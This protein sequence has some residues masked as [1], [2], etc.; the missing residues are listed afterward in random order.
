MT[1][2]DEHTATP[3][4]D[5]RLTPRVRVALLSISAT[6]AA[7]GF[8]RLLGPFADVR[9]DHPVR[10]VVALVAFALAERTLLYLKFRD[11][12]VCYTPS[13]VLLAIGLLFLNPFELLAARIVGAGLGNFLTRR[14]PPIKVAFHAAQVALEVSIA[15]LVFQELQ[16]LIPDGVI[17]TWLAIALSLVISSVAGGLLVTVAIAQF[18]GSLLDRMRTE[19]V[20]GA[21]LY[22]PVIGVGASIA[23]PISVDPQLGIVAAVPGP[24]IWLVLRIQGSLRHE[25][26]DLLGVHDFSRILGEA[27]DLQSLASTAS[28]QL[29]RALRADDVAMRIW[30]ETGDVIDARAGSGQVPFSILPET[31]DDDAWHEVLN[32]R[33]VLSAAELPPALWHRFADPGIHNAIMTPIR[34]DDGTLGVVVVSG[35]RGGTAVFDG[36]A[37]SRLKS[38]AHQLSL[39]TRKERLRTQMEIDATHDRLTSLPNRGHFEQLVDTFCESDTKGAVFLIDLD[40]F[41][42]VNDSFGHH[43]GDT[44]LIEAARRI[45]RACV[46]D[47]AVARF[48]GDEFAVFM[49]HVTAAEAEA[50]AA[51]ITERLEMPFDIES[52]TVAIGAS[53][54]IAMM[55]EHGTDASTLIRRADIAM[56]DAKTRRAQTSMY[57]TSLDR[58]DNDDSSL[59]NDLR[60][61]LRERQISVHFQPQINVATRLVSG[62]E[63]LARWEHPTRGRINPADFIELAEQAGLIEEV[64]R[65]ILELAC[66][67]ADRWHAMG[68]DIDV[69]VNI[70]PRSLLDERLGPIVEETLAAS[71]IDSRRLMLEITES[72]MVVHDERSHLALHALAQLGVKLSVDDFGT[73]FSSLANLR[74]LP[75]NEIKI[76]R[77]FV[78][79]MMAEHDDEIIVRSTVELGRNL[80]LS[81][82]AE[83]VETAE[84]F[85]RLA[86]F[87]C[88]IA[89]GFGISRPLPA[90]AFEAWLD[91]YGRAPIILIDDVTPLET[92]VV[93]EIVD[94]PT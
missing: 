48:G 70:S 23:V 81:V 65:Q 43:A 66:G 80:G 28:L 5:P 46:T 49:Q 19:V 27:T 35:R 14:P 15:A 69:S 68:F 16:P 10:F 3:S 57:R 85:D 86:E 34:D 24:I 50:I 32:Q 39:A 47:D 84:M 77:S 87:G 30:T 38:M 21:M 88:D 12:P 92:S 94:S 51:S 89:Q 6:I 4:T 71:T 33:R 93:G 2:Q 90:D 55:P 61:A 17:G 44:L 52:S 60:T 25:H 13:E 29:A 22:L 42:Q 63:A 40:R 74:R 37:V 75:V 73:G 56:F 11:Q 31:I 36:E 62:A 41:K 59:L 53:I 67:A 64:S 18:E 76:D 58:D 54:G 9:L 79:S 45:G 72:T 20:S 82:V 1:N 83:G 7:L 8:M 26:D 78:S 91:R